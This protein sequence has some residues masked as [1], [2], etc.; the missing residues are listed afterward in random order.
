MLFCVFLSHLET[1]SEF[2]PCPHCDVS[3]TDVDFLE[4]HVKWVH[5]KQYLANLK[6]CC[7]TINLIP[8]F[9]CTIC[10]STFKTKVHLR[11]HVREA[12]PAPPPRRLHPCPTC[13]RSFQYLKNLKNHC[14]RWHNMRVI[15]RGGHLSCRDCGKSFKSTWGQGPHLCNEPGNSEPEDKPICLDIDRPFVC[16]DCGRRFVE[17]SGWRQHMKIHTGEKPYK[18]EVCGKA[19]IRS[20]HLR[21]HLSTHSGKKEYSCPECGKEF[22][23]KSSLNHHVRTHSS[24]KPFHCSAS[25]Q[26]G[27]CG[28]K[29]GDYG[30]LKIHLRTHTGERPY[31]CTVCGNKFIRLSHLRNHQRTHTG[32]KPYSCPNYTTSMEP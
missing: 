6:K 21:C 17:R 26:C 27:D 20:H 22:G 5:Q 16:K 13:A 30:A 25:H 10:S 11:I 8:T 2:F 1:S 29:I 15:T 7:R 28:L 24:E 12:H 18:C 3:F 31:H 23:F 14:Q 32:E 4:K 19:F 9:T